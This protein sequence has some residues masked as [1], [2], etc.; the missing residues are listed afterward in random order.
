[1][2]LQ[3]T[4][5]RVIGFTLALLLSLTIIISSPAMQIHASG[6]ASAGALLGTGASDEINI[7]KI[8]D[9]ALNKAG[10][11]MSPTKIRDFLTFWWSSVKSDIQTL[12]NDAD[13]T[14]TT[15][16]DLLTY[17]ASAASDPT[18][19]DGL[20][21]VDLTL[22]FARFCITMEFKTLSDFKNL[23]MQEGVFRQFLLS[24]VT[25]QDGNI[26]SSVDNNK[27]AKYQLKSGFI[28]MVRQA[29]DIYIEE[30]EGYWMYPSY[31]YADL[32]VSIFDTKAEYECVIASLKTM[33]SDGVFFLA[34]DKNNNYYMDATGQNFVGEAHYNNGELYY[35]SI[36]KYD[37]N[38]NRVSYYYIQDSR[39]ESSI[40]DLTKFSSSAYKYNN[41]TVWP[42]LELDSRVLNW[43]NF[44]TSDGRAIKVWK[45][46]DA[47][48]ESSVGKSDIYYSK[49][50]G[51]FEESKDSG[52]TFTGS[53]YNGSYSHDVI[54]TTIDNSQVTVD[55]SVVNNIVNNYITNNY[56]DGSGSGGA[57][58]G[59]GSG[60]DNSGGWWDIGS[61]IS[62]FIE[63]VASL[64]DFVLKILGDL[65]GLLANFLTSVL[66]VLRGLAA[67]GQ[68]FGDFLAESFKFLPEE[69]INIIIASIGGMCIAGVVKAFI[70]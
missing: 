38:W 68:G 60:N 25:D 26:T 37:N 66:D 70:K 59:D 43:T 55:N 51:T 42:S 44:F 28:S 5:K 49:D 17:M 12:I 39:S 10:I 15:A 52:L 40:V 69:C 11:S 3:K 62:S 8:L 36:S 14:I 54:Q 56:G 24:Y 61:G 29:A 58:S 19:A 47:F 53:Y 6:G 18:K 67:L 30:Y 4:T 41:Y 1:M 22:K 13:T 33:P 16:S 9:M 20:E 35:L 65:V 63:G 2:H 45:S 32:S 21:M 27:L 48:K 23:L 31:T 64:L 50:Y 7:V 46:L 34:R 57:V